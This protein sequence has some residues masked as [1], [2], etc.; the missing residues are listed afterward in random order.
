MDGMSKDRTRV[1][2]A[3][4]TAKNPFIRLVEFSLVDGNA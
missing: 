2:V 3:V 4:Y 1:I